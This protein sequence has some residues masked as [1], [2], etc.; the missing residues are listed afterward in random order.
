MTI[1]AKRNKF[2][3]NLQLHAMGNPD[4]EAKTKEEFRE[5][6]KQ[7]LE[8]GDTEK[9]S[10]AFTNYMTSIEEAVMREAQGVI[11]IDDSN[12]LQTRGVRQLT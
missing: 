6:I 2:K 1:E 8:S 7:A 3:M 10:Q 5:E 9:F 4:M 12:I 11:A